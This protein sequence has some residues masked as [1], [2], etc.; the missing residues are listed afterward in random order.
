ME[1]MK[2]FVFE[3]G[4]LIGL[5]R[6]SWHSEAPSSLLP[7]A[8]QSGW[9]RPRDRVLEVGC[10]LGTNT[11]WLASHDCDVTAIDLSSVAVGRAKKRLA[12]E[13]LSGNLYQ[14]DFLQGLSEPPFDVIFDRATL[15]SFPK[16]EL[17]SQ[18]AAKL[19]QHLHPGGLMLLSEMRPVPKLAGRKLPPFGVARG[20]LDELFGSEFEIHA[21]GEEVQ[22]HPVLGELPFAQW[23]VRHKGNG[24]RLG[25]HPAIPTA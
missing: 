18:F 19:R 9:L 21:V 3:L 24:H 10:G 22:R 4:Y 2:R 15:H 25:V 13:G 20:E 8:A 16:G 17:R 12:R 14:A 5:A 7:R 6:I 11:A 23:C 1:K